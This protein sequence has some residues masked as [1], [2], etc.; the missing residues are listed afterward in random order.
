MTS[1]K[2]DAKIGKVTFNVTEMGTYAVTY[3]EK[4]FEDT[5]KT[6]WADFMTMLMKP[7]VLKSSETAAFDDVKPEDYYLQDI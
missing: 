6:K 7:F 1:R 5:Y 4:T 2:Y 3:V